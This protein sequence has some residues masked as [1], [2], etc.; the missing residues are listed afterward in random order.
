MSEDTT[1]PKPRN[2][3]VD[4]FQKGALTDQIFD[5]FGY[6]SNDALE[7]IAQSC[8]D[9][10]NAGKIDLF[11]LAKARSFEDL[12]GHRFFM[13]QQFL[14][15][16]IPKLKSPATNSTSRCAR[17]ANIHAC[18]RNIEMLSIIPEKPR[19]H[20][21]ARPRLAVSSFLCLPPG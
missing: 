11:A 19:R 5:R 21:A 2:S 17:T 10:H 7:A 18:S 20:T 4:A 16:V 13:G 9:L 3:L 6:A 14:C 15:K 12:P 1:I 8:A